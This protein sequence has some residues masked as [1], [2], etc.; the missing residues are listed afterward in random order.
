MNTPAVMPRQIKKTS[1]PQSSEKQDT[2]AELKAKPAV[3]K[4]VDSSQRQPRTSVTVF[5]AT[6]ENA[7]GVR[8]NGN[9]LPTEILDHVDVELNDDGSGIVWVGLIADRIAV[10]PAKAR[11]R[12]R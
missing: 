11:K 1:A 10:A 9:P 5:T 7:G 4:P 12:R 6:S 2:P 8:V 3:V